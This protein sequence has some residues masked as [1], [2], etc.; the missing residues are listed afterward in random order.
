MVYICTVCTYNDCPSRRYHFAT[1]CTPYSTVGSFELPTCRPLINNDNPLALS[2][3]T[4]DVRRRTLRRQKLPDFSVSSP[5]HLPSP[6]PLRKR[7]FQEVSTFSRKF[8]GSTS[9]RGAYPYSIL[10][11]ATLQTNCNLRMGHRPSRYEVHC[12][13]QV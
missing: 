5:S 12:T 6:H 3:S 1:I 2:L 11:L 9:A 7:T 8:G 4:E 13:V 10:C